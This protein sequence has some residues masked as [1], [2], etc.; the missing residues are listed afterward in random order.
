MLLGTAVW[1]QTLKLT[2]GKYNAYLRLN[3]TTQMPIR[4]HVEIKQ[5]QNILVITNSEER[6]ELTTFI[7]SG[8]SNVV[9]FP[10][11]DSELRFI[12]H[13]KKEMRGFWIN[14]NKG[15][16]YKIP[17]YAHLETKEDELNPP[18]E[19]M[20][21]IWETRFSPKTPDEE[22]AKGIFNQNQSILTGTFQTETGDYRFLE[23]KIE[24][25]R[26]YLSAFDGSHAFLIKGIVKNAKLQ[27]SFFSGTHYSTDF[28]AIYN[29]NFEL[30]NP[31]SITRM[32]E[33]TALS[34]TLKNL[35]GE[36]YTYPNP[37]TKGKVVIIQIMGTWCPNCMDETNFYK[38][39][40][41]TYHSK[42]LEI[43]SIGYEYPESFDEQV[44]KIQTLIDR[45]QLTFQFLVGGKA[46]K[47]LA[48]QQF[49]ML[50]EIIS[51]PTSIFIGRD[52]EVKR[53]HTGFNGPGT[54]KIYEEYVEKT[55][56]L[57]EA[58]LK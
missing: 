24:G 7:K 9:A 20:Q 28:S 19:N 56:S 3:E 41:D 50:N 18:T 14:Y 4:L 5:K 43:I 47:S 29:P 40:Y 27:G 26:F 15:K 34:F 32:K 54:G 25:N 17:F 46:S 53:V 1:G 48:S 45:K 52:G 21:G 13:K 10:S 55:K 42:G 31:D 44:K 2:P 39:L 37:S 36:N 16:N 6:I 49:S 8:D 11:F 33:N 30:R 57:I 22:L 38:E 12:T 51:F 23:G 35:A 58:L